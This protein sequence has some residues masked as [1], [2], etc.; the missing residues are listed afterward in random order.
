MLTYVTNSYYFIIRELPLHDAPSYFYAGS[1]V[2]LP[3]G[4][5]VY[6]DSG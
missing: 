1:V 6:A 3:G 2:Q 4:I 5:N